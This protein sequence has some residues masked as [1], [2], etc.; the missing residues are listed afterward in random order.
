MH[1]DP[2]TKSNQGGPHQD[3]ANKMAKSS[4]REFLKQQKKTVTYKG[5]PIRHSALFVFLLFFSRNFAGQ[6]GVV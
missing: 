1:R 4:D 2:P 6:K 5:N 3:T